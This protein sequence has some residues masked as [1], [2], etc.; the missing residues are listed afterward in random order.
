MNKIT[1]LVGAA[2]TVSSLTA[3]HA[4]AESALDRWKTSGE[5]NVGH[6]ESS[7]PFSYVDSEA[8]PIGFSLDL[9]QQV[10]EDI[11]DTQGIEDVKVNYV[12]VTSQNRIILVQNGTVDIECGSTSN[13]VERQKQVAFSYNFFAT[14][15]RLMTKASSGIEA[16]QDLEG[17]VVVSYSGSSAD[18]TIQTKIAETGVEPRTVYAKDNSD[19]FL[20]IQ[21]G[22]GHAFVNDD[23]LLAGI[24]ANAE[25]PEDFA[26]VGPA[27]KVEP[28][29]I[30]MNR[31]DDKLKT[32]VDA[33]LTKIFSDGRYQKIYEKW[34]MAPVPP[35]GV[36]LNFPLS[37]AV[38]DL[39]AQPTDS[40]E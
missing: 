34:F 38:S 22:R 24:I 26:I 17:K 13:T 6:R 18:K 23:I 37:G 20:Y 7:I 33:A 1:Q 30:M 15:V 27:L 10:I 19:A 3:N 8:G 31:D 16:F 9:C 29:A 2:C 5:I 11:A 14:S 32:A 21:T 28:Y 36:N 12:P 35:R 25:T 4:A 39:L 40:A